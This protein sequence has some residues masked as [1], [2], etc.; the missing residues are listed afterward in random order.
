MDENTSFETTQRQTV[1]PLV[2]KINSETEP[3]LKVAAK[4]FGYSMPLAFRLYNQIRFYEEYGK[5]HLGVSVAS[6]DT[7]AKQFGVTVKQIDEAYSNLTSRYK[8]GRWIDHNEPVFRGVRRTW[9]SLTRYDRGFGNSY[10][11]RP[12]L[13]HGKTKTLT[14]YELVTDK[15]PLSESKKKVIESKTVSKDTEARGLGQQVEEPVYVPIPEAKPRRKAAKKSSDFGN[16]EVQ[17][18]IELRR[19]LKWKTPFGGATKERYIAHRLAKDD[20]Y[21]TIVKL[22]KAY[23]ANRHQEYMAVVNNL[24]DFEKKLPGIKKSLNG[25]TRTEQEKADI[26]KTR[27]I[28]RE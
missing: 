4:E 20:G 16:S 1:N 21:E 14:A 12:E 18:I 5:L 22:M 28:G 25:K 8:L 11:V 27:G 15:R 6:K 9:V 10:A 19:K 23:E 17:G 3:V 7:L 24:G 13:L 26:Y 2:D